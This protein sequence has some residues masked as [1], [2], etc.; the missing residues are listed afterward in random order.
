MFKSILVFMIVCTLAVQ[1]TTVKNESPIS[2]IFDEFIFG[3]DSPINNILSFCTIKEATQG[4]FTGCESDPEVANSKCVTYYPDLEKQV[5]KIMDDV[6][7]TVFI[8]TQ[9]VNLIDD[10]TIGINRYALFQKYC[11]FGQ[12]FTKLDNVLESFA[13]I[14]TFFYKI[15]LN[16]ATLIGKFSDISTHYKEE[17]CQ[18]MF[19]DVGMVFSKL[20]DFEVPEDIV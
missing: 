8:P 20:L 13:G 18:E 10:I 15:I 19:K 11:E 14:T 7:A 16:Y 17:K 2:N 3:E 4:F 9:T 6:N 12:M 5:K 1:S